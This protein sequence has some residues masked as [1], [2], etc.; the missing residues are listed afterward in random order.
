MDI[1]PTVRATFWGV[2]IGM[3]ITWISNLGVNPSSVQRFLAVPSIQA[4]RRY[5]NDNDLCTY[6]ECCRK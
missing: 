1:D 3:G 5:R 4:A 2:S 6:S